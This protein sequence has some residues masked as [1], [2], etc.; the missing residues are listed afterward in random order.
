MTSNSTTT[1][2]DRTV[3]GT[4]A[5][6]VHGDK[7]DTGDQ[8]ELTIII[9]LTAAGLVLTAAFFAVGFGPEFGRILATSG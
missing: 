5:N 8:S 2:F 9:L 6:V 7:R 4:G 3:L 1:Q